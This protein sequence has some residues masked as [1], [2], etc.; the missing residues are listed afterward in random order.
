[1]KTKSVNICV[2]AGLL[3]GAAYRFVQLLPYPFGGG[4]YRESPDK[5][6]TA[7]ANTLIDCHFFGGE[8]RYY[9]FT[10]EAGP[11]QRVRRIEMTEPPEGMISWRHEG[12]IQ[13]AADS[14]SV[15]YS[16]MGT[17]LILSTKP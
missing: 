14:S 9:E 11:R 7:H 4:Q 6:F 3:L 13:W 1:L 17:Q 16:F 12:T 10:I 2:I 5:Q 8:R 15:T